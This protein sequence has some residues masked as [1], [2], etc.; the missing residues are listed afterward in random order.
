MSD[1]RTYGFNKDDAGALIQSISN[2]EDWYPEIKP[3]GGN[4]GG[5]HEIWFTIDSVYCADSYDAKHLVVTATHYSKSC[6]GVPP[7]A[8]ADGTYS[9]Y[10]IC[11]ILDF[12]TDAYLESGGVV[13]RATYMY[14]LTGYCEPL[15]IVDTICGSPECA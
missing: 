2:G 9:I 10:D 12:Y 5:N 3:R 11:S 7:G 1:E 13:G 8:N 14:P 4:K 6:T 15:W